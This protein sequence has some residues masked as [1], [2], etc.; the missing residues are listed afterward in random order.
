[1]ADRTEPEDK[2][3]CVWPSPLESTSAKCRVDHPAAQ[4]DDCGHLCRGHYAKLTRACTELPTA[5]TQML[6]AINPSTSVRLNPDRVTGT[7]AQPE[8]IR[9][10]AFDLAHQLADLQGWTASMVAWRDDCQTLAPAIHDT[11]DKAHRIAPWRIGRRRIGLR[12]PYCGLAELYADDGEDDAQCMS[13]SGGCGL[14]V[15]GEEIER[16]MYAEQLRAEAEID[17]RT[18]AG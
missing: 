13:S 2:P 6:T 4:H 5:L 10:D 8:A 15:T 17:R 7:G 12:C 9:L 14:V 18:A 16:V 11:V 3:R 1:M